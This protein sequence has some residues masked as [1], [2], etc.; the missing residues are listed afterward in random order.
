MAGEVRLKA[1]RI[2]DRI[3][4]EATHVCT[5]VLIDIAEL[6]RLHGTTIDA[7]NAIV[8]KAWQFN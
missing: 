1:F 8:L 3:S 7:R 4:S 6:R 5:G 2:F